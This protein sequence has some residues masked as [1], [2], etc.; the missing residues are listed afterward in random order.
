M[1]LPQHGTDPRIQ[2]ALSEATWIVLA[3]LVSTIN[4]F[5]LQS[6]TSVLSWFCVHSVL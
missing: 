3:V 1:V 5:P 4:G 2:K 6:C